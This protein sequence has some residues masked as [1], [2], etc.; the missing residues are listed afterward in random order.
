M[1]VYFCHKATAILKVI[2]EAP[3]LLYRLSSQRLFLYDEAEKQR[4]SWDLVGC[5]FVAEVL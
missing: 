3:H 5:M 2:C 1:C 4:G